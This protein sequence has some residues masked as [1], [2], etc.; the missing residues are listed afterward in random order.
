MTMD[1]DDEA[2]APTEAP[3]NMPV[4]NEDAAR[5]NYPIK[6][7]FR[8]YLSRQKVEGTANSY[9]ST[10]DNAVRQWINKEVDAHADPVFSYTTSEDI[11]LCIDMLNASPEYVA[12][13]DRKHHSMSAAL[14]Q[15]M[16]FIEFTLEKLG[17]LRKEIQNM[18]LSRTALNEATKAQATAKDKL[19]ETMKAFHAA[20]DSGPLD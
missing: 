17:L 10:L 11:R 14:N 5:R 15:Y 2:P 6:E 19:D 9:T 12:E 16:Q 4:I 1:K 18:E 13:N 3:A 8:S 20:K 7:Q